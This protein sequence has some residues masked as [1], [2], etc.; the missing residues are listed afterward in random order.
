MMFADDIVRLPCGGREVNMTDY[1][2]TLNNSQEEKEGREQAENSVYG[3]R[4][5][6]E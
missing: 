1:L 6:T 3:F 4:F 2:D 5:R